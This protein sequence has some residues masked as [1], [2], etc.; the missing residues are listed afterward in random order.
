VPD[1]VPARLFAVV[2]FDSA[3]DDD[4][5]NNL[6]SST[7][8]L[9][10][11]AVQSMRAERIGNAVTV[12]IRVENRGNAASQPTALSIHDA[13]TDAVVAI[14]DVASLAP[15]QMTDLVFRLTDVRATALRAGLD[16]A[17]TTTDAD[18]SNNTATVDLPQAARQR[19]VRH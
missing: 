15:G 8:A 9:S 10:D 5:S 17:R 14:T 12:V 18:R 7:L 13:D 6:L 16:D 3:A 2:F 4:A 1:P 19:A 11:C